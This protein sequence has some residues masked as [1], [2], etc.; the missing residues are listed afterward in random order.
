[1]TINITTKN[2][3][4]SQTTKENVI[5]PAMDKLESLTDSV[6]VI[7]A[8]EGRRIIVK[9]KTEAYNTKINATGEEIRLIA[10]LSEAIDIAKR[11]I[12]KA[13]THDQI[14][15]K[16]PSLKPLDVSDRANFPSITS[17]DHVVLNTM[18]DDEAIYNAEMSDY[19]M[20]HYRDE[21]GSIAVI[22]KRNDQYLK[23]TIE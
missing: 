18:S 1:M 6:D 22:V 11:K 12:R 8:K 7:V 4:L 15:N 21:T 16:Q 3:E 17:T 23:L 13:K 19:N 10:A 14:K 5:I 9:V 2:F 20:F